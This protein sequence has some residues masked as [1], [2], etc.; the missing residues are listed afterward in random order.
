[1]YHAKNIKEIFEELNITEQGLTEEDAIKRL[2][3]YG[4]NEIP[5]SNE[6]TITKIF[7]EQFKSP[8]VLILLIAAIFSIITKSY[9]DSIFIF[10]VILINGVIGTYQEWSSEKSAEKLQNMIKIRAKVIRSR[11]EVLVDSKDVVV[12]DI[13]VLESGDKVSADCRLIETNNLSIDESILTGESVSKNKSEDVIAEDTIVAE[14]SNIAYAGTIVTNGRGKAV[15]TS[16]GSKTEFGK[17]ADKVITSE[18][19]K[20]PLVIRMEKFVKQIS[21]GFLFLAG[22]ISILLYFKGYGILEI[23]QNVVALTV[24]AIPEGLTIAMT[25]VLS[26]ASSKMAK[27]NVIVKKLNAV[28]SLGSCTVIATDKTGTL[29]A[30]EQTAKRIVLPSGDMAYIKGVGYDVKGEV[31]FSDNIS[32][33]NKDAIY[34]IAKMG[35]L[36]NEATLFYEDEKIKCHGDA[37]DIAF[38]VLGEKMW[39]KKDEEIIER[40]PYESK[41]KYSAITYKDDKGNIEYTTKGA[42]EK[43]LDFCSY[44]KVNGKNMQIDKEI[45][46]KQSEEL[47]EQGFRIIALAKGQKDDMT[48]LGMVAFVDPVR[49]DVEDAIQICN[50]AGIKVVMITGDNPKT[51]EAIGN[52]I[53]I[54]DIHARATP[55][56]K[57]EIVEDFKSKGE[58]IAVTGDGV[59]DSPAL[60]SANIG[61]AM[62]SGTD[63]AKETGNMIISDDNFSTIVKGVEEGRRAYNNIRKVIYLL[64]STGFSEI[65]LYVLSIIF[66]LPI[67]LTAI[68]LLWLN[69]I[70]NGIQGDALAFEKDIDNVMNRKVKNSKESIVNKLLISEIL[71]SSFTMAI[72]EF[73][74]YVYLVKYAKL[75]ISI[76]RAYLLTLMVFMENIHIFNCRSETISC[77]RIAGTN[78]KFLIFS[79]LITSVIQLI[80]VRVPA[81]ANFFGLEILSTDGA[82]LM[83]IFTIPIIVV[84]ELFKRINKRNMARS[85]NLKC[86]TLFK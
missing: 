3:T 73:I 15:V 29:T 35:V 4:S 12:G 74:L 22:I 16:V 85:L 43:I 72:I 57:L 13:L 60:K 48:F 11:K 77:F 28:E 9:S 64:L 37:I 51:A 6:I 59:N 80:I 67:P 86:I 30:N 82:G 5:K 50:S 38:L 36:N 41:Q 40:I 75:D 54:K 83:L 46:L 47:A 81:F 24:S 1:M 23:F 31:L 71:I 32:K 10:L 25:I 79:I 34:E 8:I 62:G 45:I 68:Q 69:L 27:R 65:I 19:T 2:K 53:G 7:I 78:N 55:L 14:R 20:S 39:V 61:I 18:S 21:I 44:M 33:E 42:P 58:F 26:I 84:M 66:G 49:E 63:I 76:I 17:I 52:R 70:S 56:Q